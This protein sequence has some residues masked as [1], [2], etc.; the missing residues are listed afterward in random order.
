[1][2]P[3]L[4]RAVRARWQ[5]GLSFSLGS[6]RRA[7]AYARTEFR[8]TGVI[9]ACIPEDAPFVQRVRPVLSGSPH[10]MNLG[11]LE[12]GEL[13]D[14]CVRLTNARAKHLVRVLQVVPGQRVRVG[15]LDGP[16][17]IGVVQ[18][19][20]DEAVEMRCAFEDDAPAPPRVDLLLA[21]PRPKV[22][23][24][25]WAQLAAMG[26]GRIILTNAE[27]V[28]RHYFDPHVL[29]PETYRPLLIEGLQQARDTRV[30]DVSIHRRFKV[31]IEDD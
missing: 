23:R 2:R 11:T 15:L 13:R 19:A 9:G 21:L 16:F 12:A 26:V 27:R 24:R 31:L 25:L 7:G 14:G 22:M 30:P 10:R 20:S 1:M 28:E 18:A 6:R 29:T 3:E 5:A 4:R 17:G 8:P